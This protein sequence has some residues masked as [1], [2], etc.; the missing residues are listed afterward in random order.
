MSIL[1]P[2]AD[3]FVVMD[4]GSTDGT[5]ETLKWLAE[6]N[7]KLRVEQGNIPVNPVTGLVDAGSFA[8]I[9]NELIPTCKNDLVMYYQ[10]DELFHEKLMDVFVER[11]EEYGLKDF[12][13]M[14]FWRYQLSHNFQRIKWFPHIVHR[15]GHKDSFVFVD[16][17]MNT[18]EVWGVPVC[19]NFDAGW[20]PRWGDEFER[21]PTELPTHEMILDISSVGG[22]LN[23]VETK[24][25][26]H[27]PLWRNSDQ[28]I[29]LD[30][31]SYKFSEWFEEQ[32]SNEEWS[33]TETPFNVPSVI[34]PSLGQH[35]YTVR[36]D[37]LD[38]IANES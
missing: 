32:K 8:V 27:A 5:L 28:H 3:E 4:V 11:L 12:K 23:N 35:D 31:Q 26:H 38:K 6:R 19:S 1:M 21:R 2:I 25:K 36:Q 29:N 9:P 10:A 15:V 37:L 33:R 16:D 20:F 34:K 24:M 14:S 30:G 18:K 13:G 22:F 17:G 7:K